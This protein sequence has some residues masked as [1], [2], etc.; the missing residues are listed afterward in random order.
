MENIA[1]LRR[2]DFRFDEKVGEYFKR[3]IRSHNKPV[4]NPGLENVNLK[5]H[6]N[7]LSYLNWLG[8]ANQPG[9]LML[10]ASK[11][12]YYD[13]EEFNSVKMLVNEKRLNEITQLNDFLTDVKNVLSPRTNFIGCFSECKTKKGIRLPSRMYKKLLH[14]LDS[15]IE[16]E[17][18]KKQISKLL[19]TIGFKV[20]DMTEING[21]TFFLTQN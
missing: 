17:F 6:D 10:P 21:L 15:K 5:F 19:E 11:H 3:I 13:I 2:T 9:L 20:L 7:F 14:Y 18:D 8:L 12:Y 1:A 4:S 16:V